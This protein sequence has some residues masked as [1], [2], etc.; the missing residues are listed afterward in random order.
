MSR[1]W[2]DE[3]CRNVPS[4]NDRGRLRLVG[5]EL[6]EEYTNAKLDEGTLLCAT[7]DFGEAEALLEINR[8]ALSAS[9]PYLPV[10]LAEMVGYVGPLV[11]PSETAC[12]RC[13]RLRADSNDPRHD[14][15][16][17]IRVH[18]TTVP[19]ARPGTGMVP[20][21][22]GILGQIAA[23][24]VVKWL[25]GHAPSDVMSRLIEINV[26]SF[27]SSIRRVLKVPRCPDCSRVMR[28]T[29]RVLE[30]GPQIP[31]RE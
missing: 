22:A 4:A 16:Q 10:W 21:M 23:M 19:E 30:H 7:S 26:V 31:Y 28:H 5:E 2:V 9:T 15:S 24:E 20:P 17:S 29:L 18:M 13:Y 12:L 25:G 8:I 6:D 27:R 11:Y 3:A 14:I 1:R